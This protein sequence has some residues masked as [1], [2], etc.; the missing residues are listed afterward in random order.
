[1]KKTLT[2]SITLI[3]T[4]IIIL[5]IKDSKKDLSLNLSPI[6]FLYKKDTEKFNSINVTGSAKRD[7]TS[8]IIAW[9]ATYSTK[10]M[11]LKDAYKKIDKDRR[12]IQ[13]Y[14]SE[15]NI[16]M[17][18]ILF[19]S[20]TYNEVYKD[21]VKEMTDGNNNTEYFREK[22]FDGYNVY[23]TISVESKSV[24]T[25]EALS[26]DITNLIDLGVEIQS[27]TP[28]YFYSKLEEM[29]IDMIA[30]ATKNA[31]QRALMITENSNSIIGKLLQANMGVFQII[32][33]NST[34]N[35]TWGGTH[36]ITSRKKT[37]SVTMK[38]NYEI[39]ETN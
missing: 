18:D 14:F 28:Y 31:Q 9:S 6:D 8:D 10:N 29:K 21:V 16:P 35:Y 30:E 11:S 15:N 13:N 20:I 12:I 23:Q 2:I 5:I 34:E 3:F 7:F 25:I 19:N 1:M 24:D 32:A 17:Q 4:I 33:K 26:R 38:L 27:N 39:G 36:N 22:E 37:A